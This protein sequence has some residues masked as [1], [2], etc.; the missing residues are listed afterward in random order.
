M[1]PK[2]VLSPRLEGLFAIVNVAVAEAEQQIAHQR[3]RVQE[4]RAMGLPVVEEERTLVAIEVLT[5]AM[6]DNQLMMGRL[7]SGVTQ[8]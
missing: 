1:R 4:L 8:H 5:S 6:R 7:I 3:K 2:Q